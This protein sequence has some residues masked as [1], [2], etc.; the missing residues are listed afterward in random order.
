MGE[1]AP[2]WRFSAASYPDLQ[3]TI[4]DRPT[5]KYIKRASNGSASDTSEVNPVTYVCAFSF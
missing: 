4:P 3:E 1:T 5:R 2:F